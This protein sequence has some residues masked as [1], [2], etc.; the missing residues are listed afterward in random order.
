MQKT[1]LV[2]VTGLSGAGKTQA[3]QSLEDLGFFCVDNLPPGLLPK[4]AEL[5]GQ[6]QGSINKI[7][8]AIDIRGGEFFASIN[9]M[10]D[11]LDNEDV[12][13]EI[14]FLEAS[15]ERLVR[16]FKETRRK[17]PLSAQG[18]ILEGIQEERQRMQELRGRAHKII[19]TTNTTPQELKSEI[20]A[21]FSGGS[22][23]NARLRMTI[24]SFGFKYGIP[25]DADIVIDVRFLP[26]PYY[27]PE[28]KALTGNDAAV[29]DYVNKHSV[30]RN[31]QRKFYSLIKF[32]IPNYILEGKTS[33]TIAVGCTG[34]Q[35]RSVTLAN[36]LGIMLQKKE[37]QG[38]Y[39]V[40][41]KH[42]DIDKKSGG[43]DRK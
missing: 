35:H 2:I 5:C 8:L 21:M 37:Q 40:I 19:D 32:L 24:M 28:L 26:N 43:A 30:T 42:R 4:F 12:A 16:R 36:K 10:F 29:Q 18:Q 15:D 38:N 9:E 41:I 31:F 25:M 33:L 22:H 13:Y 27:I 20:L 17:H 34:G 23:D 39:K 7:A 3:M 11:Y 14:L 6:S 1:K